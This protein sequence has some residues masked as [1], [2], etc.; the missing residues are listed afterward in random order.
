MHALTE[1]R[2][3]DYPWPSIATNGRPYGDRCAGGGTL[4]VPRAVLDPGGG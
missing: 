2:P 3:V 4:F 1:Q